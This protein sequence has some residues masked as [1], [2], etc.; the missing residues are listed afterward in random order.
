MNHK[1]T[2]L[3]V[4]TTIL[5]D[6]G[7]AQV[8]TDLRVG[9]EEIYELP[10]T[11]ASNVFKDQ[12]RSNLI[13]EVRPRDKNSGENDNAGFPYNFIINELIRQLGKPQREIVKAAR[14]DAEKKLELLLTVHRQIANGDP[15]VL[16]E[17]KLQEFLKNRFGKFVSL[18]V[19]FAEVEKRFLN[20]DLSSVESMEIENV[21]TAGLMQLQP[22]VLE[23]EIQKRIANIERLRVIAEKLQD[24]QSE[25]KDG[26]EN[27]EFV[28]RLLGPT[29]EAF[30]KLIDEKKELNFILS[31]FQEL[32]FFK[33]FDFEDSYPKLAANCFNVITKKEQEINALI[34]KIKTAYLLYGVQIRFLMDFQAQELKRRIDEY[35]TKKKE[36]EDRKI[37]LQQ[38]RNKQFTDSTLIETNKIQISSI[39][40]TIH[41]NNNRI[42]ALNQ[43]RERNNLKI[44]VL[45]APDYNQKNYDKCPVGNKYDF[46][47]HEQ[48]L[49]WE[50]GRL[51]ELKKLRSENDNLTFQVANFHSQ[52]IAL[53]DQKNQLLQFNAIL[54]AQLQSDK[55]LFIS[56]KDAFEKENEIF[57]ASLK[58]E[59]LLFLTENSR[60]SALVLDDFINF[61]TAL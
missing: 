60:T 29:A 2:L 1:L 43:K 54:I 37:K 55:L 44:A 15:I 36:L 51:N 16:S 12:E 35:E 58:N 53:Q 27:I 24:I 48:K 30:R 6:N 19:R 39:T 20:I 28:R 61:T 7:N 3:L 5:F 57:R 4:F 49:K 9:D 18:E 32:I 26:K 56:E 52:N 25:I 8:K 17:P 21:P 50:Q 11:W 46:C 42:D 47:E 22:H 14:N 31:I 59:I 34:A 13:E 45:T 40:A 38:Q 41:T 10:N 23:K 33:W